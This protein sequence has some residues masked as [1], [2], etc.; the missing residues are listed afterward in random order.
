[1]GKAAVDSAIGQQLCE[2]AKVVLKTSGDAHVVWAGS[3]VFTLW[4]S[5]YSLISMCV[6]VVVANK[7]QQC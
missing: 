1:M 4:Q 3:K 5:C 6:C 2:M 7:T